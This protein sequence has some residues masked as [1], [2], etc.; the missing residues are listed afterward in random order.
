MNNTI[1]V[2]ADACPAAMKQILFKAA[3]RTQ[4]PVCL[5]ANHPLAVPN[6]HYIDFIQVPQGIDAADHVIVQKVRASDLVIT[7]DIPLASEVIAKG[8]LALNPRG[9]LYTED[10]IAQRLRV[11][12]ELEQLRASGIQTG[13]PPPLNQK[14]KQTFASALEKY[15][16]KAL[17]GTGA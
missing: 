4:I 7:A 6:S 15:L 14:D 5:L 11:R 1:W 8:A 3:K 12:N 2:D 17:R 10:N 13:G 16:I 9:Q